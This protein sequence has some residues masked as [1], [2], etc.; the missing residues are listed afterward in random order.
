MEG[1]PSAF[2]GSTAN[3]RGAVLTNQPLTRS[4][5]FDRTQFTGELPPGWDAELYRN[6]ALIA[7][8]DGK[9][10]DGRYHF[11]DVEMTYGDNEFEVILYGPQGQ[12]QHRHEAVNVGQD[13]VPKGQLWYW[14]GVREPGKDLISFHKSPAVISTDP[15]A[16]AVASAKAGPEL[17][18]S[19]E[20]GVSERLSVSA[21]LRSTTIEDERVTYV[22]GAVR[23]SFG[24]ALVEAAVAA[25][26]HGNLAAR[27]QVAAKFGRVSVNAS[28]TFA[29]GFGAVSDR[30]LKTEQRIAVSAPLRF[31]RTLV[32]VS[33]DVSKVSR[34]DGT[35]ALIA[36]ARLG[37]QIGRFNLSSETH[38]TRERGPPGSDAGG[39]S[40][41]I[42]TAAPSGQL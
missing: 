17:T 4:A 20:Y 30:A 23:Q 3:G 13:N 28:S 40:T 38:Y 18:A 42:E 5:R 8:D 11:D 41:T 7:F 6:G 22:E 36:S 21:L 37:A 24:R 19:A 27:A 12:E 14:A 1:L 25:D 35:S 34:M 10:G 2:G 16:P 26:A 31:G 29:N 33:A 39:G 15:S 9:A 32:P